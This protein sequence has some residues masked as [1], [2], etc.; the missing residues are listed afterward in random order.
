MPAAP[1]MSPKAGLEAEPMPSLTLISAASPAWTTPGLR[2]R[3]QGVPLS[4][5]LGAHGSCL[6]PRDL[7]SQIHPLTH[8]LTSGPPEGT[9]R[10]QVENM[11]SAWC[12][13]FSGHFMEWGWGARPRETKTGIGTSDKERQRWESKVP[14]T[15]DP[16]WVS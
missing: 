16:P 11:P 6:F 9:Q 12:W 1:D 8:T 15:R 13:W 2:C 7:A 4:S 3:N 10:L 14:V 5:S